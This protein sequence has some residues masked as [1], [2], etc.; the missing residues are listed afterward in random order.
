MGHQ[1][2][3]PIRVMTQA[4][5]PQQFTWRG[6][7]HFVTEILSSWRLS[8]RWWE[9]SAYFHGASDRHYYRLC[10][11]GGM[12]CEIYYDAARCGWILDRVLD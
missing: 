6:T 7:D 10:C 2:L 3:Q 11:T 1:Y 4:G 5:R 8:D 9:S 12:V